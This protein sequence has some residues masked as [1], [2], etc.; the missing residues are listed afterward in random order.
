MPDPQCGSA[1]LDMRAAPRPPRTQHG[2]SAGCDCARRLEPTFDQSILECSVD[3]AEAP[4]T[5]RTLDPVAALA[6]DFAGGAGRRR[7]QRQS[8]ALVPTLMLVDQLAN[9][10]IF[11]LHRDALDAT[12]VGE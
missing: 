9:L 7:T 1:G 3:G 2:G 11:A 6:Q 10:P 5:V 12:I 4:V 8:K